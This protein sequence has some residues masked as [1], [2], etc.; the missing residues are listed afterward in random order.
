MGSEMCIRD[1]TSAL[2][3]REDH[4]TEIVQIETPP[5]LIEATHRLVGHKRFDYC[6]VDFRRRNGLDD[7]VFLEI[8]SFPM[9]V[10]FD[11]AGKMCIVDAILDFLIDP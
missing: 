3:Y 5:S 6:A 10:R 9:F 1:R 11:D 7:P 4:G 8:N 2:D